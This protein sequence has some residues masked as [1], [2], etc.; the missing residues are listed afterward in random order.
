[1]LKQITFIISPHTFSELIL[2]P[3]SLMII[4]SLS[5]ARLPLQPSNLYFLCHPCFMSPTTMAY[6]NRRKNHW[7][8]TQS[9]NNFQSLKCVICLLLCDSTAFVIFVY[10][11]CPWEGM[12]LF[13]IRWRSNLTA[14]LLQLAKACMCV[15]FSVHM[16]VCLSNSSWIGSTAGQHARRLQIIHVIFLFVAAHPRLLLIHNHTHNEKEALRNINYTHSNLNYFYMLP[17][18]YSLNYN[19]M[20]SI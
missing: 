5:F 2:F 10:C 14:E 9:R 17:H 20:V 11:L 13:Q 15:L 3:P 16:F 1:M 7:P 18:P 4:L 6:N 12:A 8:K 19:H